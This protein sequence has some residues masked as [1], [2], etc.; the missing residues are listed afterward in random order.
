MYSKVQLK[1]VRPFR[2]GHPVGAIH[3]D[4]SRADAEVLSDRL[5]GLSLDQASEH[6]DPC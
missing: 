6:V 4:G 1:A 2:V 3:F 5:A